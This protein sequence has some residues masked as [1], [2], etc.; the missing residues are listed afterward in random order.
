MARAPGSDSDWSPE[1]VRRRT[2]RLIVGL[3]CVAGILGSFFGGLAVYAGTWPPLLVVE[4]GSM[5][6]SDTT[7]EIGVLDTG[8]LA[9]I[10]IVDS[11]EE[12]VTYL[13]GRISGYTSFGDYGDVIVAGFL[14]PDVNRTRAL[15]H[16]AFAYVAHNASGGF[17]V[18]ELAALPP[19]SWTG[20]TSDGSAAASPY[21]LRSFVVFQMGW[22]RDVA[23]EWNLTPLSAKYPN[24]GFLT[25]G[26]NNLYRRLTNKTDPWILNPQ[27]VIA[28]V[29]GE[30][31]WLGLVRLTVTKSPDGCCAA[32]GSTDPE[33]GAP[34]NSW[35]ALDIVIG[36]TILAP[37]AVDAVLRRMSLS[38]RVVVFPYAMLRRALGGRVER[39]VG[40][41]GRT[42]PVTPAVRAPGEIAM[43]SQRFDFESWCASVDERIDRLRRSGREGPD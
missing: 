19:S 30:I 4:S 9:V 21:G 15:V 35:F 1:E 8:D 31:P 32:W 37:V 26:D 41:S 13:E 10:Q 17:D 16:R 11:R 2:R 38:R 42:T 6:H 27:H 20:V 24:D 39:R 40:P 34:G 43:I 5:Q 28:R 22:R 25:F 36:V 3:V 7:G 29:R 23:I 18:P 14:D 12:I 33:V